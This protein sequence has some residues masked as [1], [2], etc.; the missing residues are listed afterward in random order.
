MHR[1][2]RRKRPAA[3]KGG[4]NRRD[5]QVTNIVVVAPIIGEIDVIVL[6]DWPRSSLCALP[7]EAKMRGA[8]GG[9]GGI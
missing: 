4:A 5:H 9:P 3:L 8:G 2:G 6:K 1:A 7:C